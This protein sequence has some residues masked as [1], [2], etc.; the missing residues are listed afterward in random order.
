MMIILVDG[1]EEIN[2][3]SLTEIPSTELEVE[4]AEPISM[5]EVI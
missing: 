1:V 3:E 4:D 5:D 2:G